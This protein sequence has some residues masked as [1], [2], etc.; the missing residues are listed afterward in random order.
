MNKSDLLVGFNNHINDFFNDVLTIFPN[1]NDIKVAYSSLI[2]IRKINP[3]II[4]SIWKSY[5]LDKYKVEIEEGNIDFFIK[6][7]YKDD[8]INNENAST[9]L[10]KI[11]TLRKPIEEM[12]EENK[13]KTIK[14]IQNL[15]KLCNLYYQ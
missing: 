5:I 15:T 4:I 12:G 8:L 7:N 10:S 2:S 6:R 9:I 14:Y 3:K 11:D 13:Q 1:D